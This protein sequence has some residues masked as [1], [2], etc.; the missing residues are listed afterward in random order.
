MTLERWQVLP[1]PNTN[2]QSVSESTAY[3]QHGGG[4]LGGLGGGGGRGDGSVSSQ[5]HGESHPEL[6]EV[7]QLAITKSQEPSQG[8]KS[9]PPSQDTR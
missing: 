6:Q 8:C 4:G 7:S 3:G 5:P 1:T 2:A 9:S